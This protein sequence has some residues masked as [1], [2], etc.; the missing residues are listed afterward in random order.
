MSLV[1]LLQA[2]L[3]MVVHGSSDDFLCTS[4]VC[5]NVKCSTLPVGC[6]KTADGVVISGVFL[7]DPSVCNCCDYCVSTLKEGDRCIHATSGAF[8]ARAICGDGLT[9]SEDKKC[10]KIN[11]TNCTRDQQK[12]DQDKEQNKLGISR[13]R[14]ICDEHGEYGPVHCIPGS[15]CYCIEPKNGERIFGEALYLSQDVTKRMTCGCSR[16]AWRASQVP[17]FVQSARCTAD[18]SYE[19]LQC[20]DNKCACVSSVDGTIVDGSIVDLRDMHKGYPSCFD[21][22]QHAPGRYERKCEK[23]LFDKLR[24]EKSGFTVLN[25]P[26]PECTPDGRYARTQ[27]TADR[28]R[29]CV[30]PEGE[31][32]GHFGTSCGNTDCNC[33]RTLWLIEQAGVAEKPVCCSDGTF[34]AWQCRRA[35][36]Y[37]VDSKGNQVSND[38]D[39]ADVKQLS[40]FNMTACANSDSC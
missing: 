27:T 35:V 25:M 12:Y 7:P 32:I 11:N 24:M 2:C 30:D 4:D 17:N 33:A 14:P 31:Q 26:L 15:I 19:S 22:Q 37:C 8:T 28:R 10:V 5:E 36:C 9:C 21:S 38:V 34:R 3:L 6:N 13:W 39:I 40:C 29:I 18:G 20:V 23:F 1:L 16:S